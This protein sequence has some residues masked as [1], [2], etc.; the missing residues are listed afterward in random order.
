ME[1]KFAANLS[2]LKPQSGNLV[3]FNGKKIALYYWNNEVSALGSHCLHKG[4]PIYEGF[5]GPMFDGIYVVC[6][7]HGWQYNIKTGAAPEGY[8]DQLARYDVKVEDGKVYISEEPVVKAKKVTHLDPSLKDIAELKYQTT[9]DS[10]NILGLST[11]NLN[12]D[13]PRYSTS[14]AALEKALEY[15][16]SLGAQTKMIKLRDLNFKACEGYYSNNQHA[17][18]WPCAITEMLPNDGMTDVYRE[19][20][21]WADVLIL[22][23]PIRWG[24]ASSLYYRMA[25]RLN[26]VQNQITLHNKILIK[27]KVASFIITGGQDNIQA[28]NG[29]LTTFFTELGFTF[30][31]FSFMGWSRGWT[32]ED[33]DHNIARFKKSKYIDRSVKDLVDNCIKLIRQIKTDPCKEDMQTP[34]P[35]I[36]EAPSSTAT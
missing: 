31:P 8:G 21:L 19:M 10:L 17:C 11:T 24:N 30:P 27:N 4:G 23:T 5:I 15:S 6:P 13:I 16:Q 34:L 32:A 22:A 20:I 18:I 33:M 35:K 26:C 3:E 25:E 9:P 29:Q 7:W 12:K 36:S 2:D 14:E 1:Y 28:V